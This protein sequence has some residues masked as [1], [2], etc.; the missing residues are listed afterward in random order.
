MKMMKLVSI[1]GAFLLIA[2]LNQN[3]GPS[4]GFSATGQ[5]HPGSQSN[6]SANP[7]SFPQPQLPSPSPQTPIL[8]PMPAPPTPIRTAPNTQY[9]LYVATTGSDSNSGDSMNTPFRTIPKAFSVAKPN[10]TIHVL[11]GTYTGTFKISASGTAGKP[12]YLWS[13]IKWGA[14]IVP[15]PESTAN[16]FG[17]Q[18]SGNYIVIDGFEID[19]QSSLGWRIGI[20]SHGNQNEVRRNH[21]HH[22][23]KS[24]PCNNNGGAGIL[25]EGSSG[26]RGTKIQQNVV[27]D[28]GPSGCTWFHGIYVSIFDFVVE[29]NL[30]HNN[31]SVGIA[32][33]H[34]WGRGTV[35]NNTVF[36]NGSRGLSFSGADFWNV[37]ASGPVTIVNNLVFENW[38]N[39]AMSGGF[40]IGMD[41]SLVAGS[42]IANNYSFNN[43]NS[44]LSFPQS[45]ATASNNITS[46]SPGFV[47]YQ[48]NGSGDYRLA[49]GSPLIDQALKTNSPP[50]D[51]LD[52]S[53]PQGA[54]FDIGAF[55]S[56][57]Q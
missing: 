42:I 24:S 43:R 16:G 32:F 1:G 57:T 26:S 34:D 10:T 2:L 8:N 23:A 50:F 36:R 4:G 41:G 38:A 6:Q 11:S 21:V 5:I 27:H 14:K 25:M 48:A 18:I 15:P 28:N 49:P 22:V 55:E 46:G 7:E 35:R 17:V 47:N 44:N 40:G 56:P 3:C 31:A 45:A 20:I 33:N 37:S 53:R 54:G 9:H 52:V 30:V 19:G 13:E 29:N 39:S 12:I 51:N